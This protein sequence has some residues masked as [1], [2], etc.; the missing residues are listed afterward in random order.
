[1]RAS[2]CLGAGVRKDFLGRGIG[3]P[4]RFDRATGSVATSEY[5]ENI[6]ENI[7]IILGTKPGERQ[8]LPEFGCRIHEFMFAPNT[9][10]T[11]TIIRGHV[12]EA[13]SRFE[14]RI[15]VQEVKAWPDPGGKLRVEVRYQ[16]RSTRELQQISVDLKGG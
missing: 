16:I 4:F 8:M 3:F 5:E 15:E 13:L 6:R 7:T 10:A 2:V 14:P 11:A 9:P 1:M 12:E